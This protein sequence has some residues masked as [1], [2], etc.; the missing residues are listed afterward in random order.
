MLPAGPRARCAVLCMWSIVNKLWTWIELI[1]LY[2]TCTRATRCRIPYISHVTP[3]TDAY[4]QRARI[5]V[6]VYTA[7][8]YDEE[9]SDSERCLYWSHSPGN[10]VLLD[11]R[12]VY[13]TIKKWH[14][15]YSTGYSNQRW[16]SE[17]WYLRNA[18]QWVRKRAYHLPSL[19]R[20][21]SSDKYP[22]SCRKGQIVPCRDQRSIPSCSRHRRTFSAGYST[23]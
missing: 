21:A 6:K 17:K 1:I 8:V 4:F 18:I 11:L 20:Q 10:S 9:G 5:L 16:D 22:E 13:I 7:L 3:H 15:R 23:K 14:R 12:Q 2:L 19:S